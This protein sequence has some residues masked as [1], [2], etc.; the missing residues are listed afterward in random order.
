MLVMNR[1]SESAVLAGEILRK[2]SALSGATSPLASFAAFA[3]PLDL[4]RQDALEAVLQELRREDP[5]PERFAACRT[6]L[7]HL[8]VT[9]ESVS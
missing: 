2:W 1:L 4:E 7:R 5:S 3:D 9:P 8:V 6:L